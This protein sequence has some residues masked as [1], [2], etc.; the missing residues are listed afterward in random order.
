MFDQTS[1][2]AAAWQSVSV[3]TD[4]QSGVAFFISSNTV[5]LFLIWNGQLL[6]VNEVRL[7]NQYWMACGIIF[8]VFVL[9][10]TQVGVFTDRRT[11]QEA[12]HL[13]GVWDMS[14]IPAK[15]YPSTNL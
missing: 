2:S 7:V 15:S 12:V 11:A 13:I 1:I 3:K 5:I 14:S 8:Q 10:V 4:Y 6:R 9:L